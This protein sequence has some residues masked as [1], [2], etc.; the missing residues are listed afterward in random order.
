MMIHYP[1]K[2][3][4]V[5]AGAAALLL[6]VPG[7]SQATASPGADSITAGTSSSN[8]GESCSSSI[9]CAGLAIDCD[10]RGGTYVHLKRGSGI[11]SISAQPVPQ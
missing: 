3:M 6:A 7:T 11:C 4:S 5:M 1:R 10:K 2:F 8:G 9:S